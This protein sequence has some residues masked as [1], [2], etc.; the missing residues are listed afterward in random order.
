MKTLIITLLFVAGTCFA[1]PPSEQ[2]L[3][4]HWKTRE[5][6]DLMFTKE[7]TFTMKSPSLPRGAAGTWVLHADGT[8]DMIVNAEIDAAMH[9]KPVPPQTVPGQLLTAS[10]RHTIQVKASGGLS[11]TWTRTNAP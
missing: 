6:I 8:I 11:D 3:I 10:G 4:G 7:H 5:N 9:Q 2:Q 1:D